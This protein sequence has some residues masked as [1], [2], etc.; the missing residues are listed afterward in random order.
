MG[1]I[2]LRTPGVRVR[3]AASYKPQEYRGEG[4]EDADSTRKRSIDLGES[5]CGRLTWFWWGYTIERFGS[6]S[7]IAAQLLPPMSFFPPARLHGIT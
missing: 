4:V 1:E 3:P 2:E 5:G 6:W 7:G